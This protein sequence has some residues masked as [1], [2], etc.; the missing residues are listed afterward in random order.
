MTD[1]TSPCPP[2]VSSE[3]LS[4]SAAV[5]FG[6]EHQFRVLHAQRTAPDAIKVLVELTAREGPCPACGVLTTAV[7]ERP[8]QPAEGPA[9]LGTAGRAVVAEASVGVPGDAVP[10]SLVH[11]DLYCGAAPW[12][13]H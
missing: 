9:S 8:L 4:G 10:A 13:G 11:P 1:A 2:E 12:P 7:K 5:L 3:V 6:L